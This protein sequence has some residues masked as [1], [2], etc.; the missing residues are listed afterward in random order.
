MNI[1]KVGKTFT[2]LPQSFKDN[3]IKNVTPSQE[4]MA[5][6]NNGY[7]HKITDEYTTKIRGA[8]DG[9]KI[10][11]SYND[12]K[13]VYTVKNGRKI[14]LKN[15]TMEQAANQIAMYYNKYLK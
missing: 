5:E 7:K 11:I 8:E 15:G 4:L 6:V 2:E 9:R 12:N 10:I 14:I 13:Y 1:N 3:I